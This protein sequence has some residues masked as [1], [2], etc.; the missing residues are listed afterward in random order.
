MKMCRWFQKRRGN[1]L[2]ALLLTMLCGTLCMTLLTH[3]IGHQRIMQIRRSRAIA[4]AELSDSLNLETHQMFQTL[5]QAD[6]HSLQNPA[7]IL[8]SPQTFPD[9]DSDSVR[10]SHCFSIHFH[11]NG[12]LKTSF[13]RD[14]ILCRQQEGPFAMEA[15]IGCTFLRGAVPVQR[16]PLL[17]K[18]EI[19]DEITTRSWLRSMGVEISSGAV[20]VVQPEG[21][22]LNLKSLAQHALDLGDLE[23]T[24][25]EIRRRL[26]LPVMDTPLPPGVYLVRDPQRVHAVLV[27]GDLDKLEFAGYPAYQ[28]IRL[29]RGHDTYQLE[30]SPGGGI[31]DCW[32]SDSLTAAEFSESVVINGD[33]RSVQVLSETGTPPPA[34]HCDSRILLLVSGKVCIDSSLKRDELGVRKISAPGLSIV[35]GKSGVFQAGTQG[36]H[37]TAKDNVILDAGLITSGVLINSAGSLNVNGGV[38]AADLENAGRMQVTPVAGDHPIL[39]NLTVQN[40]NMIESIRLLRIEEV[41]RDDME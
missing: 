11:A 18:A 6:L 37:I 39:G 30:Y 31:L 35:C 15:E 21:F 38:C 25:A 26:N 36:I 7:K 28:L 8:F 16:I 34:F 2:A 22:D 17:L 13:A 40:L 3:T 41:P 32:I 29:T 19:P 5:N 33:C 27:Q 4:L 10:F 1:I 20:P 24:W 9:H 23:L 14:R 12:N